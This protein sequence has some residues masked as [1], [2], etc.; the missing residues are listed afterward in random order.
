M[1]NLQTAR[2]YVNPPKFQTLP[3]VEVARTSDIMKA[4]VDACN[5]DKNQVTALA[6]HFRKATILET[7]QAVYYFLRNNVQYVPDDI[8]KMIIKTVERLL[9]DGF[10][11]CKGFSIFIKCVLDKLGILCFFRF[12]G[13]G[14]DKEAT[15]VYVVAI[16]ENGKHIP[17]DACIDRF[18]YELPYNHNTKKDMPTSIVKMNGTPQ[19][20]YTE[21]HSYVMCP[22]DCNKSKVGIGFGPDFGGFASGGT[23]GGISWQNVG[24]I[25]DIIKQGVGVIKEVKDVFSG[26]GQPSGSQPTGQTA[27][28]LLQIQQEIARQ[29]AEQS[30][31]DNTMLY[32]GGAILAYVLLSSNSKKK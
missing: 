26:S 10:A 14:Q 1:L 22:C 31:P 8:R 17:I 27:Q 23:Q 25:V 18:N 20:G 7:C 3:L 21:Y 6:P 24:G 29:Q 4:V 28:E 11:D 15:H 32:I 5:A 12:V 13:Y 16:S 30:K 19:A 2:K 9:H